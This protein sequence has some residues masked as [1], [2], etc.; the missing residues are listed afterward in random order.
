MES[1]DRSALAAFDEHAMAALLGSRSEGWGHPEIVKATNVITIVERVAEAFGAGIKDLY[2]GLSEHAHPNFAGMAATYEQIDHANCE[3]RFID[4]PW[5]ERAE[6]ITIPVAAMAMS[7]MLLKVSLGRY[8]RSSG[9][10]IR[11][12]EEDIYRAGT[13]PPTVPYPWSS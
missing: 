13:W 6:R 3:S 2:A 5:K 1:S 8:Q 11:A 10:L 4:D 12:C 9:T 7:L